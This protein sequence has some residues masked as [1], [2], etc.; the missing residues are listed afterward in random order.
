MD[1]DVYFWWFVGTVNENMGDVI[2][3]LCLHFYSTHCT[4]DSNLGFLSIISLLWSGTTP[5]SSPGQPGTKQDVGGK[6]DRTYE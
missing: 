4:R 6:E 5:A 2:S 1:S 3:D